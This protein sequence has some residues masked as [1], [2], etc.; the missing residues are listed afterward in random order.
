MSRGTCLRFFGGPPFYHARG[1]GCRSFLTCDKGGPGNIFSASEW[2]TKI[3]F[4]LNIP[5]RTQKQLFR[6]LSPLCIL[7]RTIVWRGPCLIFK[8][9]G[10]EQGFLDK[11]CL[12]IKIYGPPDVKFGGHVEFLRSRRLDRVL[13]FVPPGTDLRPPCRKL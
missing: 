9:S 1:E 5:K 2:G 4:V 3:F 10:R 11:Q 7:G 8:V 12:Q 13:F 6:G